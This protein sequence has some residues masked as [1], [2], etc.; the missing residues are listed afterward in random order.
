M[1]RSLIP[2]GVLLITITLLI[3]S[4]T[5][6][7]IIPGSNGNTGGTSSCTITF[8]GNDTRIADSTHWDIYQGFYRIQA[9]QGGSA[10]FTLYQRNVNSGSKSL[11]YQDLYW[12]LQPFTTY[13][14]NSSGGTLN[15]INSNYI[16]SGSFS[17]S[18]NLYSGG[19]GTTSITAT[20]SN[21]RQLG[22]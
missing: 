21:V 9:F 13:T 11:V 15:L 14:V 5:K 22:S 19:T 8:N 4:C 20:F 1:Q 3:S 18:G 16:L 7:P 10:L 12:A 17:A 2:I 6:P